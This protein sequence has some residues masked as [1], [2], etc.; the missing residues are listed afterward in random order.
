MEKE[1]V[2]QVFLGEK[3]SA[4]VQFESMPF[5]VRMKGPTPGDQMYHE[6]NFVPGPNFKSR[7]HK[8]VKNCM[9]LTCFASDAFSQEIC[10]QSSNPHVAELIFL[11]QVV[12]QKMFRVLY[13]HTRFVS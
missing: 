4:G 7:T 2:Q 10:M 13:E 9:I 11:A 8:V 5:L 1:G 12:V 3:G 6:D